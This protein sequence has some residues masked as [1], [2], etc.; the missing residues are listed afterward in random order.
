MTGGIVSSTVTELVQKA[1]LPQQSVARQPTVMIFWHGAGELVLRL[2]M[3]M[4]T[5]AQ[6][7]S[8]AVGG[9][10]DQTLPHCTV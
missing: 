8:T 5:F 1:E 10:K 6:Q 7:A 2:A 3:V 4:A 9:A